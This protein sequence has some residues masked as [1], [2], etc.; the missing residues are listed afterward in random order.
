MLVKQEQISPCEV[1]LHIQVDAEKV[2]AAVDD[3]YAELGKTANI[4]GF[5]KGKAPKVVLEKVLDQE[6]VKDRAADKLL[7]SAYIEALEESKLEPYALADVDI[8]KFEIGEPLEFKAIVPL[9]P[10]VELG[11][12]KGIE[13]ERKVETVTDDAVEEELKKILERHTQFPEIHERDAQVGDVVRVEM[14]DN[15]KP[16]AEMK[17][18][19]FDIGDALPEFNEGLAGMN[20]DEQKVISVTYP[21]DFQAEEMR[22][23]TVNWLVKMCDI[24]E[25]KVPEL[26][27]EWV[28]ETFA[29]EQPEGAEPIAEP[30]DTV[31]KLR[32][33]IK[34]VMEE[35][36]VQAADAEV[37]NK[38][39]DKAIENAKADFPG[40]LV[41]EGV[42]K[43]LEELAG[44]LKKRQLT[45]DDFLK[46]RSISFD[47]L[48]AEYEEA[49]KKDL[50]SSLVLGEIVTK[51]D[52]KIEDAD[53]EEALQAMADENRVPV[54]TIKAYVD[55]T[56][57]MP[58]VRNRILT[59]KVIDF[60]VDASNIKNVG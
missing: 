59:K 47:D 26:T 27:D 22:G 56:K 18:N 49:A 5:R 34:S 53:V 43:R 4:P 23:K 51:E 44:Q 6:R 57:S 42:E 1:E 32:A 17:S 36:A 46:Y 35:S 16:D 7:K 55:R 31:E 13:A 21:D 25:K 38:V 28:K 3:T 58:D 14:K 39:V 9:A 19:V 41:N 20:P 2:D 50:K 29:P 60:L 40:V 8:I 48:R 37:R 33:K 45:I 52:I 11:D 15:D 24:H 30:I 10:K 54:E 12:Y